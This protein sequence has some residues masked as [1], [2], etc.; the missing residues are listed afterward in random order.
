MT[1]E[2]LSENE[3]TYD[4]IKKYLGSNPDKIIN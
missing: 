1:V 3:L 2:F 4:I